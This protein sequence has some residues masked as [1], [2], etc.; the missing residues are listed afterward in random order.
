MGTFWT[1]EQL[2]AYLDAQ[3]P[4]AEQTALEADLARDAALWQ[5]AASLRQ[6]VALVQALPLREPP[7]NYLLTPAMVA[8][9]TASQPA[10]ARR[11][12]L[13]LWLMRLATVASAVV[14]VVAVGLN[15]NPGLLP[16]ARAPMAVEREMA[17]V[18]DAQEEPMLNQ[19]ALPAATP[20]A[21]EDMAMSKAAPAP[22]PLPS[23]AGGEAA[24]GIG[25]FEEGA[26]GAPPPEDGVGGGGPEM[27][28]AA[29]PPASPECADA[30]MC[31]ENGAEDCAESA[32]AAMMLAEGETVS[33]T[34]TAPEAARAVLSELPVAD[35][36]APETEAAPLQPRSLIS[37]WLLGLLG[38][39]T[40]GLG[41]VTWRLSRRR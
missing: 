19:E 34:V 30:Q 14:F 5:R 8:A 18:M 24:Y 26:T 25:G 3:L 4:V 27:G 37:P 36:S 16:L 17:V 10:R 41:F 1:E 31:M 32:G 6:T 13:P 21:G 28:F 7:R 39:S 29:A 2:S 22:A 11:N 12:L 15:L 38:A 20:V 33:E 9:P 40:A 23:D 35:T